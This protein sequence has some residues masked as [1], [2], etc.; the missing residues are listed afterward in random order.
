MEMLS[1]LIEDH[2]RSFSYTNQH[3]YCEGLKPFPGDRNIFP[4]DAATPTY[5]YQQNEYFI[6]TLLRNGWREEQIGRKGTIVVNRFSRDL[7]D[8]LE[9]IFTNT[10]MT[11]SVVI[12][13]ER[14]LIDVGFADNSL[15]DV[16]VFQGIEEEVLLHGDLYKFQRHATFTNCHLPL[17]TEWWSVS[18]RVDDDWLQL[19]RFPRNITMSYDDISRLNDLLVCS[20]DIL[21][22]RDRYF[23]TAKVTPTKRIRLSCPKPEP[24]E[25]AVLTLKIIDTVMQNKSVEDITSEEEL[26]RVLKELFDLTLNPA[27]KEHL[28]LRSTMPTNA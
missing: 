11:H 14:Y 20:P 23:V 9:E 1:R 6:Q 10:L 21:N 24:S 5:C 8:E 26:I 2:L 19:W 22:I 15:R 27:L 7:T 4:L 3:L 18:I 17:E 16:L 28:M 12:L 25:S 13:D